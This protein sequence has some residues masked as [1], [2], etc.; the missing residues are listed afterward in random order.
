MDSLTDVK[1]FKSKYNALVGEFKD[2]SGNTGFLLQ[3]FD[4]RSLTRTNKV[5][6]TFENADGVLYY[7]K[8][9]PIINGLINNKF[10]IEL[11]M[12]EGIFVIPLYK[13]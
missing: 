11:D 13:K 2:D 8:G 4:D 12:C 7:R 3:N 10:E 1:E 9:E 5:K 6:I